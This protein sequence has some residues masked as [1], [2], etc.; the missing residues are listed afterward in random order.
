VKQI[1]LKSS[2]ERAD[3]IIEGYMSANA[4]SRLLDLG[5]LLQRNGITV[6]LESVPE[7]MDAGPQAAPESV[8]DA[9]GGCSPWLLHA[10]TDSRAPA[11][12]APNHAIARLCKAFVTAHAN[13]PR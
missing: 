11:D 5:H 8:E 3:P 13:P 9:P 1:P 6:A 10:L 12:A 4:L 2:R 7:S